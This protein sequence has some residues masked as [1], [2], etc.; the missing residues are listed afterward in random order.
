MAS[1]GF[2]PS[3]RRPLAARAVGARLGVDLLDHTLDAGAGGGL[4]ELAREMGGERVELGARGA[5]PA[6]RPA[7]LARSAAT[8]SHGAFQVLLPAASRK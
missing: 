5:A 1:A 4:L 3:A 7:G 6:R 8:P 2:S